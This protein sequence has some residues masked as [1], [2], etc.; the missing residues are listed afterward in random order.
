MSH[1]IITGSSSNNASAAY[2]STAQ[3]ELFFKAGF[4]STCFILC[5]FLSV[6][7]TLGSQ[8]NP[9]EIIVKLLN[10][11]QALEISR[12]ELDF[13]TYGP[14]VYKRPINVSKKI[15]FRNFFFTS[16]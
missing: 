12:D 2:P 9:N 7:K 14:I 15:L 16:I 4:V 13:Y 5:F 6:K 1:S 11:S 10:G 3:A 8:M